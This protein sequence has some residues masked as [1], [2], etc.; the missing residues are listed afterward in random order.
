MTRYEGDDVDVHEGALFAR[1]EVCVPYLEQGQITVTEFIRQR[2]ALI[3]DGLW[4]WDWNETFENALVK[5]VGEKFFDHMANLDK[6]RFQ[7]L[8]YPPEKTNIVY[9]DYP[10]ECRLL[11][12]LK[13]SE[14]ND[15]QG[16]YAK[17]GLQ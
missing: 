11:H 3:L 7:E 8:V 16:K 9:L 12:L 17:E 1:P 5:I 6:R 10:T 4:E 14:E 13:D 2:D 15:A